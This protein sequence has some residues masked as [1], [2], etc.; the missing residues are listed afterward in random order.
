MSAHTI[1]PLSLR[2]QNAST[3]LWRCYRFLRPYWK[4]TVGSYVLLL[5]IT[6]ATLITPQFI[7]WIV[8]QGIEQRNVSLLARSIGLLM[9]LTAIKS[10]MTFV[11]G[12]WSEVISQGVAYDLRNAI[13]HK[14]AYLSFAYHDSTES[15]QLLA[16]AIRDVERIRFLTGRAVLRI[17]EGATLLIGTAII[18]FWMNPQLALL[19]V[20][21]MPLL[22]WR[23]F[24]YGRRFRPISPRNRTRLACSPARS[25]KTCAGR[26]WSKPL[27]KKKPRSTALMCKT[28]TGLIWLRW[29]RASRLSTCPCWI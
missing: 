3:I 11:Q 18:L 22:G 15:G 21:P 12:R 20:L 13:H 6:A 26:A 4:R 9:G 23:A 14:L 10:L 27:P 16:L 29:A 17:A 19:A 8:D 7:R 2:Q 5:L 28:I 1:R 25:S 24:D